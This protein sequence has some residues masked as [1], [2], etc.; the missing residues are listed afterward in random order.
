MVPPPPPPKQK[1]AKTPDSKL[2]PE[3]ASDLDK[4]RL[5]IFLDREQ[6]S[7][8]PIVGYPPPD[9]ARVV[10]VYQSTHEDAKDDAALA[11]KAQAAAPNVFAHY[12]LRPEDFRFIAPPRPEPVAPKAS[13]PPPFHG[14]PGKS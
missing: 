6:F 5:E 12:K 4:L 1:T 10:L 13:P 3:A 11:A 2:S 14:R 7:A 9:F 8:G